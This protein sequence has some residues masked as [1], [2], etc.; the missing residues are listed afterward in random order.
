MSTPIGRVAQM[1]A[2]E[3]DIELRTDGFGLPG[4][5][6]S[7]TPLRQNLEK[8]GSRIGV[9]AIRKQTRETREPM[10]AL[11]YPHCLHLH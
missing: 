9:I 11:H 3:N 6:A 2:G 4:A 7:I 8:L 5:S 1:I 10:M